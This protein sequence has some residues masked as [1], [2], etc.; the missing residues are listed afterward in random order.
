MRKLWAFMISLCFTG[1]FD[2]DVLYKTLHTHRG[3][4]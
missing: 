1:T 3:G 2:P 4:L